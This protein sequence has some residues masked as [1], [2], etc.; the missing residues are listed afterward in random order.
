MKKRKIPFIGLF[1]LYSFIGYEQRAQA[2]VTITVTG[3]WMLTISTGDLQGGAGSDLNPTY[4]SATDQIIIDIG[5]GKNDYW[6]VDVSKIDFNWDSQML[7]SVKRTS[8]GSGGGFISGGTNYLLITDT[9]QE[10]FNGFKKIDDIAI[11]LQLDGIS[12]EIPEDTYSTTVYYTI[13]KL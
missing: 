6:R 10:F 9:D 11:Q 7:L 12:L 2:E 3:S 8:D 13:Y 5:S 1:I 4:E